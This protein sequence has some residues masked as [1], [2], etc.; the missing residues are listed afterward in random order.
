MK[1]TKNLKL[2]RERIKHFKSLESKIL[3]QDLDMDFGKITRKFFDS[4]FENY[5]E[6]KSELEKIAEKYQYIKMEKRYEISGHQDKNT[7]DQRGA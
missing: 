1:E 3:K 4:G 6:F 7:A 2:I 5:E